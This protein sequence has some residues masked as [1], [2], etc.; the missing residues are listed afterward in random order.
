MFYAASAKHRFWLGHTL[1][2]GDDTRDAAA[3][4]NAGCGC[5]LVGDVT[6]HASTGPVAPHHRAESILAAVPW[7]VG[8]FAAW[9]ASAAEGAAS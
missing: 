4:R 5:A 8:R 9:E 1:Y 7:I 2:V 3:A 6:D